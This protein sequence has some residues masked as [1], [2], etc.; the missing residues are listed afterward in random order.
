MEVGLRRVSG[1]CGGFLSG[2]SGDIIVAVQ[3]G[4]G[5]FWQ[6]QHL[7]NTDPFLLHG[8][9]FHAIALIG[10]TCLWVPSESPLPTYFV[11]EKDSKAENLLFNCINLI[12]QD[13][14]AAC[15][16]FHSIFQQPL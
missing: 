13:E 3:G 2:V 11:Q 10:L 16:K 15:C 12:V 4:R 6:W 14:G 9:S 7:L 8:N 1:D 5:I